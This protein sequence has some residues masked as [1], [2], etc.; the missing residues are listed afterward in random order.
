MK[1]YWLAAQKQDEQTKQWP[2]A[3]ELHRHRQFAA[4]GLDVQAKPPVD[5]AFVKAA[6]DA[7]LEFY[8]WTVDDPAL[9]RR[10]VEIGVDGITTNRVYG[11]ASN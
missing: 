1:A 6:R 5:A 10:M 8:V 7:G 11:C 4:D 3:A 9:A 2:A